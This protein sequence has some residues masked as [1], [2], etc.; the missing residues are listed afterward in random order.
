MWLRFSHFGVLCVLLALAVPASAAEPAPKPEKTALR[1]G[2]FDSRALALVHGRSKENLA[3]INKLFEEH[4]RLKAAGDEQKMKQLEA[5]GKAL[6]QRMHEQVFSTGRVD[7]ILK[8]IEDRL[9]EIAKEAGVDLIVSKWD[10]AYRAPGAEVVDVTEAL[11][12][13]YQPDEK[14]RKI[15]AD[16]ARKPPIP[17]E[18]LKKIKDL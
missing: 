11:V 4:K 3:E 18:E 15:L 9:P 17:L 14:T 8:K 6:Q 7:D 5:E 13:L 12:K 2:V 1:V 10:L 16:M